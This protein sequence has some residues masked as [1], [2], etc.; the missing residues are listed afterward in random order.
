MSQGT[1]KRG[2]NA[3]WDK[4][5]VNFAFNDYPN[6]V[7]MLDNYTSQARNHLG[8]TYLDVE[9]QNGARSLFIINHTNLYASILSI[10]YYD[11]QNNIVK[12]YRNN[13][14]WYKVV[15]TGTATEITPT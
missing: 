7:A 15:Y 10:S 9:F 5:S 8:T 4:I 11:G 3:L 1:I 13:T 12:Y 14:K 2:M 6:L